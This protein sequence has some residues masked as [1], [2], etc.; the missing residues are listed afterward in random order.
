MAL[1]IFQE[2]EAQR[3]QAICP[4]SHSRELLGPD[5]NVGDQLSRVNVSSPSGYH[6]LFWEGLR[7]FQGPSY[8]DKKLFCKM[9]KRKNKLQENTNPNTTKRTE[10]WWWSCVCVCFFFLKREIERETSICFSTYVCIHHYVCSQGNLN[11]KPWRIRTTPHPT[12]LRSPSPTPGATR[13]VNAPL[14]GLS[15]LHQHAS[16][17][18]FLSAQ[19]DDMSQQFNFPPD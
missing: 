6:S 16:S 8:Q 7:G 19:G 11:P 17:L 3:H 18:P 13:D 2:A 1:L 4:K 12:K 15:S 5:L 14:A 9:T 10:V